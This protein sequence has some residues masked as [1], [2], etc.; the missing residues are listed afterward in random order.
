MWEI[1]PHLVV[2]LQ[3]ASFHAQTI[4]MAVYLCVASS[5]GRCLVWTLNSRQFLSY[6]LHWGASPFAMDDKVDQILCR[7][8]RQKA[9]WLKVGYKVEEYK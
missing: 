8:S 6:Q 7:M 4:G 9:K 3:T 2:K 1:W 5:N